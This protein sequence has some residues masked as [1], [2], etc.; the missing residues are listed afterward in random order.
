M[1]ANVG[2]EPGMTIT[3]GSPEFPRKTIAESIDCCE[4]GAADSGDH[5]DVD[6]GLP[7]A[8]DSLDKCLHFRP[9]ALVL[10]ELSDHPLLATTAQVEQ[11]EI[12]K[13]CEGTSPHHLQPLL[14]G[15]GIAAGDVGDAAQR[16]IAESDGDEN[17]VVAAYA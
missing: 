9:V 6:G 8:T 5:L 13:D 1:R 10:Y 15:A 7:T 2:S 11:S 12:I 17:I 16:S 14:A 3:R 4:R